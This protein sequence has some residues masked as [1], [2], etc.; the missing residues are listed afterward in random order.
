MKLM[1]TMGDPEIVVLNRE[2]KEM[3]NIAK[4]TKSAYKEMGRESVNL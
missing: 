4:S 3:R 1:K 2:A